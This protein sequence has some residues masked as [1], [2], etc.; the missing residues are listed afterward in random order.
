MTTVSLP[1]THGK[2]ALIDADASPRI[3]EFSWIAV[4]S[5]YTHY[6]RG[7]RLHECGRYN[8][9]LH[10]LVLGVPASTLVDHINRDGLD[11]TKVNLR[12]VNFGE[13]MSNRRLFSSNTSGFHGVDRV[14]AKKDRW[15]A[16]INHNNRKISLGTFATAEEAARA[17]DAA[18]Y[19]LRGE[20]AALN[21]PHEHAGR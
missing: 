2:V 8:V 7:S 6:A 19:T 21:F 11:N 10:H 5:R 4:K 13:N 15:R 20:H 17:F 1:L 3:S 14:G 9:Y 18:A 16:K 12:I